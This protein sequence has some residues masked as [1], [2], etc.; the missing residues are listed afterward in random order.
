MTW[1]VNQEKVYFS[2]KNFETSA[3]DLEDFA[4]SFQR[5]QAVQLRS[6]SH[7]TTKTWLKTQVPSFKVESETL[8]FLRKGLEQVLIISFKTQYCKAPR[9]HDVSQLDGFACNLQGFEQNGIVE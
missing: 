3:L 2:F 6:Q 5:W 9:T 7:L 4:L 1:S 8:V